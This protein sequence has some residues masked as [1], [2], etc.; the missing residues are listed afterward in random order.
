MRVAMLGLGRMGLPMARRLVDGGHDVVGFDRARDRL[1]AFL[2]YGGRI[3]NC[4]AEAVSGTDAVITMLPDEQVV[5]AVLFDADGAASHIP[6][7]ALLLEMSTSDAAFVHQCAARL[8]P[9]GIRSY[10]FV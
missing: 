5:A 7:G 1:A 8:S 9:A 6:E 3:A 2:E 10:N 4:P